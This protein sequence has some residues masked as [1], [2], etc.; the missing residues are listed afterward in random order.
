MELCTRRL[1]FSLHLKSFLLFDGEQFAI[2]QPLLRLTT[3]CL[4]YSVSVLSKNFGHR[5]VASKLFSFIQSKFYSLLKPKNCNWIFDM[6][7]HCSFRTFWMFS[8]AYSII[9]VSRLHFQWVVSQFTT[10]AL[11]A[12]GK[13]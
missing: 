10:S 11:P 13:F 4:F 5:T 7:A 9:R 2:D 1:E 3:V 12:S 8:K 6:L